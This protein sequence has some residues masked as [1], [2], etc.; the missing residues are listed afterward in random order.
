MKDA[1]CHSCD[2]TLLLSAQRLHF[3]I[4]LRVMHIARQPCRALRIS[5]PF[6]IQF[7]ANESVSSASRF[8]NVIEINVRASRTVPFVLK[9]YH[10]N[11]TE[12]ATRVTLGQQVKPSRVHLLDFDFIACKVPMFN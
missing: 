12:L 6:S 3:E 4:H 11:F 2:A 8:V 7:I 1:D 5:G 9:I 10:I